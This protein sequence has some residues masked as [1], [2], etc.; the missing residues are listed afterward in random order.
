MSHKLFHSFA[1]LIFALAFVLFLIL[2]TAAPAA[3]AAFP[4]TN[5]KITFQ[6]DRDGNLEIYVMNAD[7][8]GQIRLTNNLSV[9]MQPAWSSDGRKITFLSDRDGNLEIYVMNADGS[10]Q[11]RLTNNSL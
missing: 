5:G 8:S 6:S 2:I 1:R 7:G 11:I 3:H 9:D 10:G 4:G